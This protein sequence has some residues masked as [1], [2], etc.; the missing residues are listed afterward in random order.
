MACCLDDATRR[1]LESATAQRR[2]SEA[3]V[4]SYRSDL[5]AFRDWLG[6]EHPGTVDIARIGLADIRRYL[7]ARHQAL[8]RM[9]LGRHLSAIRSLFRSMQRCGEIPANPAARVRLPRPRK[10]LANLLGV[11]DT[12]RLMVQAQRSSEPLP[13]RDRAMWELLYG[14]GLRVSELVGLNMEGLDLSGAW[15]RVLGKGSREREVPMTP[16]SCEAIRA[17]LPHRAALIAAHSPSPF[18]G[19]VFVNSR[20]GR[21][22]TRSVHRLLK[23]AQDAAGVQAPVSPHGLRH[24]FATHLLDG[25]ADLRSIQEMLGHARLGTTQRYTHVSLEHM[26]SVYDACH[27]RARRRATPPSSQET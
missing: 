13:L 2:F 21:L 16:P 1:F 8:D 24:S 18:R 6:D 12:H 26:M 7:G 27:P 9:S 5:K 11:D 3:T 25:G 20:G 4:R 14:S 19:P 23:A 22:T 10:A 17:W 15:V